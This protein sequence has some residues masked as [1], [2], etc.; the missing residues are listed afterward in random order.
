MKILK[1]LS[2]GFM[3]SK[4]CLLAPSLLKAGLFLDISCKESGIKTANRV[5]IGIYV[6]LGRFD[7]KNVLSGEI[8]VAKYV[9]SVKMCFGR[10]CF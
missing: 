9:I 4:F 8:F 2:S 7:L 1:Y 5:F 6:D 3:K 10:S